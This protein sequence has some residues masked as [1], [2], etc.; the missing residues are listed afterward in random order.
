[1]RK[2][3]RHLLFRAGDRPHTE[4]DAEPDTCA[5]A[6]ADSLADAEADSLTDTCADAKADAGTAW[7]DFRTVARTDAGADT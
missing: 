2:G 7:S 1:M 3:L 4:A 5:D 6:E